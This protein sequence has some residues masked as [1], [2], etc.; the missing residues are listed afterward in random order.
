MRTPTHSKSTLERRS[1]ES[2]RTGAQWSGGERICD[3]CW[4][5]SD[6]DGYMRKQWFACDVCLRCNEQGIRPFYGYSSELSEDDEPTTQVALQYGDDGAECWLEAPGVAAC[7]VD[8][9]QGPGSHDHD[10]RDRNTK[11]TTEILG[12]AP[13]HA[14]E[15]Q[16]ATVEHCNELAAIGVALAKSATL[17]PEVRTRDPR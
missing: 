2:E 1:H 16:E 4:V 3:I 12:G 11:P 7:D 17:L 8:V 14:E 5:R 9:D 15:E 6:T 10:E 13:V